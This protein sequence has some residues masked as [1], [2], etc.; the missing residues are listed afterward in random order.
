MLR[1]VRN[2]LSS[3]AKDEYEYRCPADFSLAK[4]TLNYNALVGSVEMTLY[5]LSFLGTKNLL[6][7]LNYC[8]ANLLE[9]TSE[10]LALGEGS[11]MQLLKS[12]YTKYFILS[13]LIHHVPTNFV[14][15]LTFY[16]CA[17]CSGAEK[18]LYR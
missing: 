9:C 3:I 15:S 8:A 4:V 5:S 7:C 12:V 6:S 2:P 10:T 1:R 14:L 13:L 18:T 11:L 17:K 16:L